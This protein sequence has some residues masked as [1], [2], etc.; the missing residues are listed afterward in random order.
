VKTAAPSA[1]AAAIAGPPPAANGIPQPCDPVASTA[2]AQREAVP[3]PRPA[4]APTPSLDEPALYLN[5]ELSWLE[6][7]Q[8]V[9]DEALDATVP[10]LERVKFVAISA[11]NLDEF[12]MVRVAGLKQQQAS[13]VAE[14]PADGLSPGEQLARISDRAQRM[15][16]DQY[17]L[18]REVL[19]PGLD[20]IGIHLLRS[21][22]LDAEQRRFLGAWYAKQ[23]YP[24]LTPLAID[25][26]HPFP[27]LR[28]RTLNLAIALDRAAPGSEGGGRDGRRTATASAAFAVVQ[29]PT[30]LGRLVE[31]PTGKAGRGFV[32]LEDVIAQNVGDLFPGTRV[33]GVW[34]F[35][36]TR[37]FDLS[38][39][40]DESEDLLKTIQKEVRRRDRGSAVRLE[41]ALG[42]DPGVRRFLTQVLRLGDADVYNIDGPL[43]LADLMPLYAVPSPR[44]ARDEPAPPHAVPKLRDAPSLFEVIAAGDVLLHHPYESFEHVVDFIEDAA[45][46]PS[47]L[48]IKQTLYRTSGDSPIIKALARAAESGKQVTALVELKA[49]FD[50][51]NNIAWAR[52]LEE[53]GVHVVYG[54]IGLKTHCKVALV[55][56]RE[57]GGIR[58]YVHLS[59]GN[60]NPTTA[61]LYT[62][63]SL[64]TAR[65]SFGTD[66][67]ALF[68]L[69]TGY[70]Q[71]AAW[72][73]FVV[74][75]I[76]LH[77]TILS[78][79][80]REAESA[81]AG[82]PGRIIAKMNA[83]VDAEVIRALYRASQAGV[84]ID[85]L[86]RGICCLRP[87]VPGV[88]DNI[89]VASV[90]D[91]FLEHSRISYFRAGGK[92]EVYLA[93]ADWM[94]RNFVRRVELMFPVEDPALK[95]HV[96]ERILGTMLADTAKTRVLGADGR[97][98]RLAPP[99]G[100]KPL[101]SQAVF[102]E[103]AS[104]RSSP[105]EVVQ[106]SLRLR[107]TVVLR[108]A[109]RREALR[110]EAEAARE[111]QGGPEDAEA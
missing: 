75:P 52:A 108:P 84:K 47:V 25:P 18:F 21:D 20:A 79:I 97:Y 9:L 64:F 104:V 65:E 3:P 14:L 106:P 100:E 2:Q 88:S 7:N 41:I 54:L 43:M 91:R 69:L 70:S 82:Q 27:H 36:L 99:P 10:L 5:R 61:R 30:V 39:D 29:V 38:Y 110:L 89:R 72:K 22:Q 8:R 94:P 60:Y 93:S 62:D 48:A 66:A 49:R 15:V 87:G 16:G 13:G 24:A 74:A 34:P 42:A 26:G 103:R 6:F 33:L 107:P 57:D 80:D 23:I 71:P 68:N 92:D 55:V 50:E 40:E 19:R 1:S 101:R 105:R 63:V 109:T 56:R 11:S 86:V 51:E 96:L 102:S 4:P 28:N 111:R 78:L 37:N 76:G 12:F 98:E 85:L 45:D 17:R 35:R 81:R 31:V 83:L 59:T 95:S 58:R 67:T 73:R 32:L 44:D 77:E 46:D 53:A 90:V